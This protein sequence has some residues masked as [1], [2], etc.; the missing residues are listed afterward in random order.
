[1][2]HMTLSSI[3]E[4]KTNQK[5]VTQLFDEIHF[6]LSFFC[7]VSYSKWLVEFRFWGCFCFFLSAL[8]YP[9]CFIGVLLLLLKMDWPRM[10]LKILNVFDQDIWPNT[11]EKSLYATQVPLTT[12]AHIYHFWG[13]QSTSH[14]L[15]WCNSYNKLNKYTGGIPSYFEVWGNHF[16]IPL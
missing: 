9:T 13:F 4:T 5:L 11:A 16:S 8:C 7:Q 1:M 2:Y 6:S 12:A 15:S 3:R 14:A 10:I